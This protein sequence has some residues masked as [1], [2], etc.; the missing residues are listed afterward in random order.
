MIVGKGRQ[1]L[2]VNLHCRVRPV[3]VGQGGAFDQVN[4]RC[5]FGPS[6][7]Q[8]LQD[9]PRPR[10]LSLLGAD[11]R[12]PYL[13]VEGTLARHLAVPG[14]GGL[15]IVRLLFHLPEIIGGITPTL[16]GIVQPHEIAP[17]RLRV[18]QTQ[19]ED[20]QGKQDIRLPR[21]IAQE[22]L[23]YATGVGK[24]LFVDKQ[25]RIEQAQ[26]PIIGTLV[27]KALQDPARLLAIILLQE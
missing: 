24:F 7:T 8:L 13:G 3:Q 25:L 10:H 9:L 14:D 20:T 15:R 18:L 2:V 16:A 21:R 11:Q 4:H 23:E 1:G 26:V 17:G 5:I 6:I 19:R 12:D 27:D 22:L